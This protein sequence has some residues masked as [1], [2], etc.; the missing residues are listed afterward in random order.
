[1]NISEHDS[2]NFVLEQNQIEIPKD[3]K[4]EDYV[5]K[6]KETIDKPAETMDNF[7]EFSILLRG[8][9]DLII[10]GDTQA[11]RELFNKLSKNQKNL[12]PDYIKKILGIDE[13]LKENSETLK[14]DELEKKYKRMAAIWDGWDKLPYKNLGWANFWKKDDK[15]YKIINRCHKKLHHDET[16]DFSRLHDGRGWNRYYCT[17]CKYK[18]QEDSSD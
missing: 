16:G 14:N 8:I 5:E 15:N 11:A 6:N 9:L 7:V 18:Y 1:M 2:E 17:A 12:V 3:K 13:K 4:S 10:Q